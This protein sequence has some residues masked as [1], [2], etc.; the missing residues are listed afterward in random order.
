MEFSNLKKWIKPAI[1]ALPPKR[2]LLIAF[3]LIVIFIFVA[4]PWF[5][6][7]IYPLAYEEF[8]IDSA[9][10]TGV[11]PYLVVAI[12]RTETKFDPNKQSRVGATG[13]MQLMPITVHEAIKEGNFSPSFQDYVS[14]PAINIRMGSWYLARL[15]KRFDGNKVAVIAAYNAGPTKVKEWLD[16]GVWD[17]TIDNVTQ[18]PYGETRHYVKRV[19]YLYQKY[20]SLYKDLGEKVKNHQ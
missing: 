18:I 20:Q 12:I 17:G 19:T 14:D 3:L 9:Q 7:I 8:I 1:V 16:K 6:R 10:V 15:T 13:L 5:N 4:I 2:A 11:D